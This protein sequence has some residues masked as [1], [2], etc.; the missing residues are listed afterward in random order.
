MNLKTYMKY[1]L[2]TVF[3]LVPLVKT[4]VQ[5]YCVNCF[6]RL[7]EIHISGFFLNHLSYKSTN[8]A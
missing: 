7:T 6:T 4:S 2:L 5:Y 3:K 8:I 1:S